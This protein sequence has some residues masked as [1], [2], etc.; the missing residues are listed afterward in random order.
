VLYCKCGNLSGE[1]RSLYLIQGGDLYNL[2]DQKRLPKRLQRWLFGLFF[3]KTLVNLILS[4]PFIHSI[5]VTLHS[6]L[7]ACLSFVYLVFLEA[8]YTSDTCK[9]CNDKTYAC[10]KKSEKV[11]CIVAGDRFMKLC[12]KFS[13]SYWFRVTESLFVFLIFALEFC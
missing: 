4:A 13:G 7:K 8:R 12:Y 11:F 6:V 3:I 1:S 9:Y 5:L 10:K 2:T